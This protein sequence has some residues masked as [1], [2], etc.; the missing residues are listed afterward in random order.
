MKPIVDPDLIAGGFVTIIPTIKIFVVVVLASTDSTLTNKQQL[1][2]CS[3][4]YQ[5]KTSSRE[6]LKSL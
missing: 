6:Q 4:L 3:L 1:N 2:L 5:Q